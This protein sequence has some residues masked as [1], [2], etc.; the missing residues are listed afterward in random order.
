MDAPLIYNLILIVLLLLSSA[1]FC[2]AEGSLFAL[3]RHQKQ[4]LFKED[5]RSS[6]IIKNLLSNPVK[7]IVTILFADEVVNVAFSSIV[8]LTVQSL[9]TES[10]EKTVTIVSIAIASP[11]LLIMGEIGPKTIAVKFPRVI[12]RA[13]AYPLH[14]FHVLIT[15]VRWVIMLISTGFTRLLGGKVGHEDSSGFSADELKILLGI[16]NEEGVLNEV[17][18]NLVS[19]FYKLENLPVHKIMTPN[20]DCFMLSS[21]QSVKK[22]IYEI[23]KRGYSRTPVYEDDDVN[24]IIGILFIKDLLTSNALSIDD[25]ACSIKKYL[26][27]P[28]FI[29]RTKMAFNLLREF[30]KDRNHIAIVV[31]EY[32]RMDGIVTLEDIL[33]EL[34][35]NIEDE[36]HLDARPKAKI[37]NRSV[38]VPGTMKIDEFNSNYLFMVTRYGGLN[39]LD[40]NIRKSVL[41]AEEEHETLGGFIFDLFGRFPT[42]GQSIDHGSLRFKVLKIH[43]KRIAEIKVEIAESE[44]ASHV[45]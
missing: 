27:R 1:F 43:K 15:P 34:F 7:L 21:R 23:K 8:G 13:V 30:Q 31:D 17:E 5:T 28:Q 36:T 44:V 33:E 16:G 39:K 2:F 11:T 24:N 22:S 41:P 42:E 38:T 6:R 10:S 4:K 45:A 35:G 12:A 26:K 25:G 40:E 29:P 3:G 14:V 18:N 9:M 32:G 37:S 20:V 19:S